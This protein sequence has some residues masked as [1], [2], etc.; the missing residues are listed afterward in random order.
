MFTEGVWPQPSS[1]WTA[2]LLADDLGKKPAWPFH[3]LTPKRSAHVWIN[4]RDD[5]LESGDVS[6]LA[7]PDEPFVKT[8]I[9]PNVEES[10]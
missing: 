6:P 10:H 1:W 2:S 5:V 3:T 4:E 7:G 9:A 8:A